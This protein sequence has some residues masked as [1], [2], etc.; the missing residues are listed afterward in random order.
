MLSMEE[1]FESAVPTPLYAE[2]K[3]RHQDSTAGWSGT[4]G[5]LRGRTVFGVK[6]EGCLV[7]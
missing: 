6:S 2:E 4:N 3:R 5:L 7:A 1:T